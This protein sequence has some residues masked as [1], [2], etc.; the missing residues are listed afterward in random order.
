MQEEVKRLTPTKETLVRLFA[1]SGNKCAFENCRH[2]LFAGNGTFIAQVCHIEAAQEGGERFRK[3]MTNEQRRNEENLILLCH[4]HHKITDNVDEYKVEK[5]K[6]IKAKHESRFISGGESIN[7]TDENYSEIVFKYEQEFK[8][9]YEIITKLAHFRKPEKEFKAFKANY[10]PSIQQFEDNLNYFDTQDQKII[11]QFADNFNLQKDKTALIFGLPSSGKTTLALG[12]SREIYKHDF[13]VYYVEL[14]HNISS[15]EIIQELVIINK[16]KSLIIVDDIHKN[17][18]LAID[19]YM[20]IED[21]QNI[22]ALFLSRKLSDDFQ[23]DDNGINLFDE[24]TM[25]HELIL[26]NPTNKFEGIINSF[27]KHFNIKQSVGEINKVLKLTN[28][29]ILKLNLLLSFWKDNIDKKLD[30]LAEQDF[31]RELFNR[32][33]QKIEGNL[34]D[35]I[36]YCCI[37]SYGIDFHFLQDRT[38]CDKLQLAGLIYESDTKNKLFSFGHSQFAELILESIIEKLPQF[39]TSKFKEQEQQFKTNELLNYFKQFSSSSQIAIEYPK[40]TAA[41]FSALHQQKIKGAIFTLLNDSSIS[42]KTLKYL[43]SELIEL[44]A[45]KDFFKALRFCYQAKFEYY[46]KEYLE[47]STNF[48]EKILKERDGFAI[49]SFVLF[50]CYKCNLSKQANKLISLLTKDEMTQLVK[51]SPV[52]TTTFSA[53]LFKNYNPSF[54]KLIIES[55]SESDW[56]FSLMKAPPFITA[57]SLTELKEINR[58]MTR[59]IFLLMNEDELGKKLSQVKYFYFEKAISELKEVDL[60]KAKRLLEYYSDEKFLN[61]LDKCKSSQLGKGLASLFLINPDKISIVYSQLDSQ[62]VSD[63]LKGETVKNA[64][65]IFSELFKISE[66]KSNEILNSYIKDFSIY[67]VKDIADHFT[68]IHTL[69]NVNFVSR[70]VIFSKFTYDYLLL[71]FQKATAENYSSGLAAIKLYNPE[72]AKL[73]YSTTEINLNANDVGFTSLG[74]ILLKLKIVDPIRSK[75]VFR[76]CDRKVLIRKATANNINFGQI[77]K[78]IEELKALDKSQAIEIFNLVA[79]ESKYQSKIYKLTFDLFLHTIVSICEISPEKGKE[80]FTT[81]TNLHKHNLDSQ[82]IS[83]QVFSQGLGK[84]SKVSK[85]LCN[86]I[87]DKFSNKL[88]EQIAGLPFHKMATG[89]SEIAEFAPEKAKQMLDSIPIEILLNKAKDTKTVT[90]NSALGEIKKFDKKRWTE[91]KQKLE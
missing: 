73:I 74:N 30:Q 12:I 24:I 77:V 61:G 7:L 57:N 43:K 19:I 25:K 44:S 51:N 78:T 10:R 9:L 53:I 64:M 55:L 40:N 81:Y 90:L 66:P 38:L 28:R 91:I 60:E 68:L 58:T 35:I 18:S 39:D 8:R 80:T 75:E 72:L 33:L 37:N 54:S 27:Q 45:I 62:I 14:N 34:Q 32:Y 11:T 87:L 52:N 3:D 36:P 59:N 67:D 48:K 1:K 17:L 71:L 82:N 16:N 89:L 79:N 86:E 21:M 56:A 69:I 26:S 65:R 85:P 29:N 88:K 84:L 5:I 47:K 15:R 46:S 20:E 41:I 23:K 22:S 13:E 4:A 49:F 42:D 6:E 83:F 76:K 31:N 63:K 70:Y 50:S 2:K